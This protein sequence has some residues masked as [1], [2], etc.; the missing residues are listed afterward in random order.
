L[1]IIKIHIFFLIIFINQTVFAQNLIGSKSNLRNQRIATEKIKII[2]DTLSIIP[3]TFEIVN[4]NA[5]DYRIDEINAILTWKR[6]PFFDSVD[7]SYRVFPFVIKDQYY[8]LKY[9]EIQQN[10]LSENP[11]SSSIN[12]NGLFNPFINNNDLQ[13]NGT[14]GRGISFG[15]NQDAVL[16]STLNLQMN[17][18]IGDSIELTAA[19]SDNALPIQ[20]D[21]NTKDL[22]DFD[23]VYLQ[24]KKKEWQVSFGDIDLKQNGQHF[25]N[26][27]KRIQG[28]SFTTNNNIGNNSTNN[29]FLSGAV[30]KGKFTKNNIT[31]IEGN[32]GPYKLQGANN[33]I[34]F[35]VLAGTEKVF[36]DGN[37][38]QRGDDQDYVIDYNTAEITFTIK[39]LIS[40]DNRI[41][42]EF[43]YADRY[44]LNAQFFISDEIDVNKKLKV[45]ISGY[46]SI[47]SKNATID[48]MLTDQ[49]KIKLSAIGDSLQRAFISNAVSDTFSIGKILYKKIDTL[50]NGNLHDS[51]FVYTSEVNN[52][53]YNVSFAFVGSGKGNYHQLQNGINGNVYEWVKPD[54]NNNKNGDFDAVVFLVTPKK[55]ELFAISADYTI[56]NATKIVSEFAMSNYNKNLFSTINKEDDHGIA[57]KIQLNT[58]TKKFILLHHNHILNANAS[59]EQVQKSFNPL[60]R[61]RDVE[62]LRDWSVLNPLESVNEKIIDLNFK[63]SG[64]MGNEINYSLTNYKRDNIY[65]GFRH[66]LTQQ[67]VYGQFKIVSNFNLVQFNN[68]IQNGNYFRPALQIVK[69]FKKLNDWQLMV[70]YSAEKNK[71]ANILFDTIAAESFAFER[72]EASL[73]SNQNN[74]NKWEISYFSRLNYLANQKNWTKSD[75]NRNYSF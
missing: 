58:S 68:I 31:P 53:L 49:Q 47:D 1:R 30:A 45:N 16:N 73:K 8:H 46:N 65:N 67:G 25:L 41:R 26:F 42:I 4:V 52:S 11:T 12:N 44:Y 72:I 23:R 33:E 13:T 18:F 56:S 60:E 10:F 37:L 54:I 29:L 55:Q 14:F 21:G 5:E 9:A 43:E 48:Q 27:S 20:P 6:K 64:K 15:N 62:F 3:G 39:H 34:Y 7:I 32:Q 63:L 74:L 28:A 36:I 35:T 61:I 2:F 40:K 66:L 38:M 17:G 71:I 51:V 19:I 50:Y 57:G 24:I 69:G 22:R 70:G 75:Q 59:Y